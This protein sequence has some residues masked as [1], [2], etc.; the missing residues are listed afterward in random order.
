MS[1]PLPV[2]PRMATVVDL[3]GE[4]QRVVCVCNHTIFDGVV[5]KSRVV[6]LLPRGGAE[7]LC[8]CKAWVAV[9]VTYAPPGTA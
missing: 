2:Q 3:T 7:A 4:R 1:L 6:R 8:R 5:I 9:P